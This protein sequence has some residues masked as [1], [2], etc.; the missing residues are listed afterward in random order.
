[1]LQRSKPCVHLLHEPVEM[2]AL[3]VSER[4]AFIKQ[5]HDVGFAAP[6][7]AIKVDALDWLL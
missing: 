1:M 4:Q 7:A 6:Y 3:L 2:S 5:I